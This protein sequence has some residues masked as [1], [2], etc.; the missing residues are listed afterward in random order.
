V[1]TLKESA[2]IVGV[3]GF[4]EAGAI[5]VFTQLVNSSRSIIV[6]IGFTVV[7]VG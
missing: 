2:V 1:L 6:Q 4:E 7:F 3:L 5:P